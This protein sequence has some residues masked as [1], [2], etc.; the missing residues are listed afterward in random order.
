[1]NHKQR[2]R[3]RIGRAWLAPQI[4]AVLT[5]LLIFAM[6]IGF[7]FKPIVF[8]LIVNPLF[9]LAVGALVYISVWVCCPACQKRVGLPFF[10][11]ML[12]PSDKWIN[13]DWGLNTCPRCGLD[14]NQE[15]EMLQQ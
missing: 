15:E 14:F 1:M 11:S 9:I 7:S 13:R 6:Q 2:I 4:L 8:M 5:V 12:H 10:L 3:R